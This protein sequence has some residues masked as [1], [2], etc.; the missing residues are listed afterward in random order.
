MATLTVCF[1]WWEAVFLINACENTTKNMKE[2]LDLG[3][4][5]ATRIAAEG[6]DVQAAY[7]KMTAQI[8]LSL[9]HNLEELKEAFKSEE[10]LLP[11]D[12][13]MGV[14][15]VHV[16]RWIVDTDELEVRVASQG[17]K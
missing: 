1:D 6:G 12:G 8:I 11:L 3:D 16:D 17:L 7:L 9:G 13:E 4:R 10:R 5:G 14:E 15:L 2:Q